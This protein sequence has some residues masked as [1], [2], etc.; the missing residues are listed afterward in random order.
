MFNDERNSQFHKKYLRHLVTHG[1][2]KII[3]C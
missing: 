2:Y 3:D 1:Q